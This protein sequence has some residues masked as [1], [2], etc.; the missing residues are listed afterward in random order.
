MPTSS[1]GTNFKWWKRA[2]LATLLALPIWCYQSYSEASML[3]ASLDHVTDS[4]SL[5][6]RTHSLILSDKPNLAMV[7]HELAEIDHIFG[8]LRQLYPVEAAATQAVWKPFYASWR[9]RP[10]PLDILDAEPVAQQF[11]LFND[12]LEQKAEDRVTRLR[13]LDFCGFLL[14][15]GGLV[16]VV[17]LLGRLLRASEALEQRERRFRSYMEHSPALAFMKDAEGRMLYVNPKFCQRFGRPEEHFLGRSDAELWSESAARRLRDQDLGVLRSGQPLRIPDLMLPV[18]GVET[19]WNIAKFPLVDEDGQWCLGSMAVETTEQKRLEAELER[20][21]EAKRNFLSMLRDE[22]R[23]PLNAM[24]GVASRLQDAVLTSE[25]AADA[26]SLVASGRSMLRL[27]NGVLGKSAS[28]SGLLALEMVAVPV[29]SVALECLAPHVLPAA[30]KGLELILDVP[31]DLPDVLGDPLRLSQ[32]LSALLDNALRCT[33]RGEVELKISCLALSNVGARLHFE[34]RDTG[35]GIAQEKQP[36]LLPPL[37]GFHESGSR[38]P[39]GGLGVA[40]SLVH[41]MGGSLKLKSRPGQGSSFSFAVEFPLARAALAVRLSWA[42][43]VLLIESNPRNAEL[44]AARLRALGAVCEA[45]EELKSGYDLVIVGVAPG[46]EEAWHEHLE[47]AA[48]SCPVVAWTLGDRRPD[49]C[50]LGFTATLEKP[51]SNSALLALFQ[52]AKAPSGEPANEGGAEADGGEL[53]DARLLSVCC[54]S[55]AVI[56]CES[57]T[58][59]GV[60]EKLKKEVYD[61]LLLPDDEQAALGLSLGVGA[62]PAGRRPV[63]LWVSEQPSDLLEGISETCTPGNLSASLA[64]LLP[65]D[66]SHSKLRELRGRNPDAGFLGALRDMARNDLSRLGKQLLAEPP[67]SEKSK[68]LAQA[69]ASAASTVGARKVER[70]AQAL[71]SGEDVSMGRLEGLLERA[72]EQ[73]PGL[74][75]A[76]A[77]PRGVNSPAA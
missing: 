2:V 13:L 35:V 45:G 56:G 47:A 19:H 29:E 46:G 50:R 49:A 26:A 65:S 67:Q 11:G 1:T 7:G 41:S 24:V 32:V 39:A 25:Q 34:V 9:Q 27:V 17:R 51:L 54:S 12:A 77:R 30:Q 72:L 44:L 4:G 63:L 68:R 75:R 16:A 71:A 23:V 57:V 70:M 38:Q 43:R 6:S 40:Q 28:E 42:P 3:D 73:L 48:L 62:L 52:H 10:R 8:E 33:R 64:R 55:G 76:D 31:P 74:L 21:S 5:E 36:G 37:A 20:L 61:V 14:L 66:F 15:V 69:L 18:G 58:P 59:E 22:L 53:S 60:L